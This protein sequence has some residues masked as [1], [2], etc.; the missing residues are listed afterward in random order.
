MGLMIV[1]ASE[2][3]GNADPHGLDLAMTTDQ[4]LQRLGM[5][6]ALSSLGQCCLYLASAPK[7]KASEI[8]LQRVLVDVRDHR[9]LPP[10]PETPDPAATNHLPDALLARRYYDPTAHGFEARLRERLKPRK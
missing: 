5:P 3:V 2:D 4:A 7:S 9:N 10:P 6:E 1:F 8:A